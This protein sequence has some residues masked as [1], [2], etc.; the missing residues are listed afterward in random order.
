MYGLRYDEN[1]PTF[2]RRENG[3]VA[4]GFRKDGYVNVSVCN[5]RLL[6][7]RIVWELHNG[8]IPSSTYIDH[9]DGN[10]SNNSIENLRVCNQQQNLG[11]SK[12]GKGNT[13]GFK[14][15]AFHKKANKYRAYLCIDGKQKHLGLF[16]N[17]E[18]AHEEYKKA[19][20]T[21]FKQFSRSS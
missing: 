14:G 4:G 13:T 16:T 20:L 12:R 8:A 1:S 17:P 2:L 9:I 7:H 18:D 11:N 6:G 19:A 15:V 10:P 3:K 5:K 21:H